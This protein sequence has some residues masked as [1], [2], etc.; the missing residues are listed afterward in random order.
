MRNLC[1]A[2]AL[3]I[4]SS[5]TAAAQGDVRLSEFASRVSPDL[6]IARMMTFDRD[7]DGRVATTELSERMQG[8][9]ARGDR[10]G[11]GALDESE[12]RQ[13]A[14]ANQFVVRARQNLGGGYGFADTTLSSRNHI[15]NS[16][17]DLR[18]A[19]NASQEAKRIAVAFVEEFEGAAL[20][21]L[22][23]TVASMVPA[24][25]W[26]SFERDLRN[27]AS[28]QTA[29]T[30][31]SGVPAG[32]TVAFAS[33]P[34]LVLN[35]RQLSAEQLKVAE[36]AMDTFSAEQQLDEARRYELVTRLGGVLTGEER[37]NLS[38]ALARRPL[39]K[40]AAS[41]AGFP[42]L[43]AQHGLTINAVVR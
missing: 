34:R 43:N 15:E 3:L 20:A 22:R 17:D 27:L 26:P 7:R 42:A 38:A 33:L 6:V 19:P 11:D 31:S 13:L 30:S 16:I 4:S 10:S 39:V 35:K 8:L 9:V 1:A 21:K 28:L 40:R 29:M 14:T 12:I 41:F 2:L 18:L 24:E 37:D 32:T 36:R 5:A 25:Q 23:S